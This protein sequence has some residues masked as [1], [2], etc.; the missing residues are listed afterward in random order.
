MQAY[1]HSGNAMDKVRFQASRFLNHFDHFETLHNFF[2]ENTQLHLP[3]TVTHAAVYTETKRKMISWISAIDD[4]FIGI[5]YFIPIAVARHIPH[6]YFVTLFDVLGIKCG[7][8][9]GQN[10]A[11]ALTVFGSE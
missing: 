5:L 2:P 4:E 8:C 7:I 10:I 9:G 3:K 1:W 6:D 11:C